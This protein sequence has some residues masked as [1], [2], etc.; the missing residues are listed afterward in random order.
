M[1][2]FGIETALFPGPRDGLPG[3]GPLKE[4]VRGSDKPADVPGETGAPVVG[5][6]GA[7]VLG[8]FGP[9]VPVPGPVPG[10]IP[11][12]VPG[13]AAA[14]GAGGNG[15]GPAYVAGTA[16]PGGGG[17]CATVGM[18][19]PVGFVVGVGVSACG[20]G[21]LCFVFAST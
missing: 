16:N 3:V 18:R 21:S 15:E 11:L 13:C 19:M 10:E 14:G 8:E 20:G 1:G 17:R 6:A 9:T 12:P 2:G 7:P 5:V 4:I